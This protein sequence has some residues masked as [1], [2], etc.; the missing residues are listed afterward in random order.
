MHLYTIE[1][2]VRQAHLL[3]VH[4]MKDK[5]TS[6]NIFKL[7]K[8]FLKE[9]TGM[10]ELTI[11]KNLVCVRVDGATMMQGQRIGVCTKL[12]TTCAPYMLGI[13]CMAHTMNL[14][15]KIVSKFPIVLKFENLVHEIHGYFYR[16][17][18]RFTKFQNFGEGIT[19][20]NK[21]LKDVD[22]RWISLHGPAQ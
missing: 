10:D 13:H 3:C 18:K 12:Q 5:P 21:L 8:K 16:S 14:A 4:K 9:I 2:H 11:A 17:P 7:V 20:G 19:P 15:F 6:Q 22:T 1:R